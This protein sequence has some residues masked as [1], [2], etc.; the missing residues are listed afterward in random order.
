MCTSCYETDVRLGK[1]RRKKKKDV[2]AYNTMLPLRTSERFY[3][4]FGFIFNGSRILTLWFYFA[5]DADNNIHRCHL[6]GRCIMLGCHLLKLAGKG[7]SA[8][9]LPWK[10]LKASCEMQST[11]HS[12]LY[13]SLQTTQNVKC[14]VHMEMHGA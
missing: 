10:R 6:G 12:L 9:K 1:R 13:P 7:K 11:G 8:S 2:D 14:L 5:L 4:H 3:P